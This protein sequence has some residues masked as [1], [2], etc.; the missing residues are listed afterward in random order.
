[1]IDPAQTRRK[2]AAAFASAPRRR[3]RLGN[4]PL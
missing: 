3:G 4:I 1:M 2:L